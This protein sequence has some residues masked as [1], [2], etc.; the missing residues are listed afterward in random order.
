MIKR[1]HET[2]E[3]RYPTIVLRFVSK[4]RRKKYGRKIETKFIRNG[5][6]RPL[7]LLKQNKKSPSCQ[8][9]IQ[10]SAALLVPSGLVDKKL[11]LELEICKLLVL[12]HRILDQEG[13]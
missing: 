4:G 13:F 1:K 9:E 6:P 8:Q 3:N 12:D 2:F 10:V 5:R 7:E 11:T